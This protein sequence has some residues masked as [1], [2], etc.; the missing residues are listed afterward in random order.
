[1]LDMET[2][3]GHPQPIGGFVHHGGYDSCPLLGHYEDQGTDL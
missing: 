2:Y 1:M 3:D